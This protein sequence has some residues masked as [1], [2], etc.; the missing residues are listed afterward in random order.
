M[1]DGLFH[2]KKFSVSHTRSSMKVGVDGVLIGSWASPTG[3]RILDAGTGCGVIALMLAQRVPDAEVIAIDIDKASIEEAS[4][5][6][7]N[8]IWNERIH[9]NNI[10]F[11]E[12]VNE[13]HDSF[14]MIVSNP[15]FFESG[16]KY[17]ATPR[18]VAR[19]QAEFSPI[20]LIKGSAGLLKNDG[21]LA[22]IVPSEFFNQLCTVGIANGLSPDRVLF[23]RN[24][25]ESPIKRVM[26]EFTKDHK[27]LSVDNFSMTDDMVLTMFDNSGLPTPQYKE[28]GK[29]FYIKF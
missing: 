23:V 8:S 15:P 16:V 19:H 3:K 21:K 5:N 27:Y 18:E 11:N 14:D 22:I 26:I 24:R 12:L 25:R 29:D 2:F 1:K 4:E 9:P 7:Q 28:L 10:S 20:A 17:P 13:E 6:F